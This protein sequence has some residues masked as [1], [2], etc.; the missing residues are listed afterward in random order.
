MTADRIA[1]TVSETGAAE[2]R[3]VKLSSRILLRGKRPC[4][5]AMS[6]FFS[7]AE[8]GDFIEFSAHVEL[9]LRAFPL[10]AISDLV[11]LP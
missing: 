4:Q 5:G 8:G 11:L 7:Q 2:S 1:T 3:S 6:S 9:T 10:P